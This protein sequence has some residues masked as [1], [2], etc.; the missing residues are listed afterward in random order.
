[1]FY[2]AEPPARVRRAYQ[3]IE[4]EFDEVLAPTNP[5]ALTL[6]RQLLWQEM[7]FPSQFQN[8]STI[9][10]LGQYVALRLGGRP[11]TEVT[12]MG[13]QTHLW[14][15]LPRDHSQL[16][17]QRGWA[18]KFAPMARAWDVIGNFRA[19]SLNG[20]GAILAGIHDSNANLL[21]YLKMGDFCLLS[22][23]TWI[24]AFDTNADVGSLKPEFDQVSNTTVF[25]DPVACCRFMGGREFEAVAVGAD[26]RLASIS[27]ASK[28]VAN[29]I[30]ATPS[31]TASGGPL[32]QTAGK[33][34]ILGKTGDDPIERASLASIYCAQMTVIA[35]QAMSISSRIIVDGPFSKNAVFLTCLR[36]LMDGHE[37]CTADDQNGTS[38]GAAMLALMEDGKLPEMS[39]TLISVKSSMI[40]GLE[41]YHQKWLDTFEMSSGD[42]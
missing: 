26:P 24:I 12:A 28:V 41:A 16:A 3:E 31:F 38:K 22:T 14:A 7:D 34:K 27:T 1:M 30:M 4:P 23:G 5:G 18:E 29:Q 10:P 8:A 19:S 35:L 11:V 33:G 17:R 2:E 15:P 9:M 21:R 6:G 37:V 13:A 42:L 20:T 39:E 40:P 25:G 32:P 36:Q